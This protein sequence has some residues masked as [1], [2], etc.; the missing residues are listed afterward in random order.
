MVHFRSLTKE[1]RP[2]LESAI[3]ADPHH[4]GWLKPDFFF[5]PESMTVVASDERGPVLF[6][7][8]KPK[9]PA[10]ALLFIQFVQRERIRTARVLNN[11]FPTVREILRKAGFNQIVFDSISAPMVAMAIKRFGFRPIIDHPNHYA[12]PL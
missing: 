7:R 8:M 11:G 9:L 5:H 3:A 12:L 4:S 1:D 6:L 10:S 2:L